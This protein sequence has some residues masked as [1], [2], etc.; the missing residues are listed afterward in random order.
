MKTIKL[1]FLFLISITLFNSTTLLAIKAEKGRQVRSLTG[2]H[3]ISVSSGIDLFLTQK[4]VEEVVVETGT[5]DFDKIITKV[6]NGIL[7][8]YL[9]DKTWLGFNWTNEPRKVHVSFKSLDKLEASAGSD[10][11][12]Q[13]ELHLENLEIDASSGSDMSLELTAIELDVASSSGS[14]IS[15]K[16]KAQVF[17]VSCSSGSDINA[18][19]LETKNCI[20]STS[21]GSD[22]KVYATEALEAH[23]SSG[24]DI[25]YKGNPAKKD[26]HKSSGGD[27]FG[28]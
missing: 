3:G 21:S 4:S 14:D 16:G 2:F 9:K 28:R 15:L 6:D 19:E 12:S 23:A 24:G 5:D 17:H 20:A 25:S 26:I 10:V 7:K 22:I 1:S 11:K 8:I 13:G 27:V 18:L